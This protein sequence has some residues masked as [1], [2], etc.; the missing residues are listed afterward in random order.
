M[1]KALAVKEEDECTNWGGG[2]SYSLNGNALKERIF[3]ARKDHWG[4][5]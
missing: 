4:W 5:G 1:K 2:Y 3:V